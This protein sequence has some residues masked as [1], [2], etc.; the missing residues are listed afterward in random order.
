MSILINDYKKNK[1]N[2]KSQLIIS[3][4]RI[5]NYFAKGSKLKKLLGLPFR[6][7]HRFFIEWILCVE[8]NEKAQIGKGLKLY[9]GQ[10][11]VIHENTIIG[12]NVTLRHATTIGALDGSFKAPK[13]GNNVNI[14]SNC[15]IIGDISIGN[16]VT[17]GA[18]SVV[19][20]D[21]KDNCTIV[22][23]PARII[24]KTKESNEL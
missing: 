2:I 11:L 5:S 17:I 14:G 8:I 20:K 16:N 1:G 9:H 3:S 21:C 10:G 19:I 12:E 23:N 6:L 24:H 18:G 7:F 15:I 22:G 13:I 4:F